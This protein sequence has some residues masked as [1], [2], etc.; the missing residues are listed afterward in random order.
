ML[1]ELKEAARAKSFGFYPVAWIYLALGDI[2]QAFEY[3]NAAYEERSPLLYLLKIEPL[4]DLVR[5]D[6]R[7][8]ALLRKVNLGG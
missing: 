1:D 8:H 7:F 6:A 3:L 5:S 4:Y 2:D